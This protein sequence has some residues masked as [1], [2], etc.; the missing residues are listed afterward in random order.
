MLPIEIQTHLEDI[1]GHIEALGA[2]LVDIAVRFG[3]GKNTLIIIADKPQG[4]ITLEECVAVN[5]RLS[6][7]FEEFS[8]Q[9]ETRFL[10]SHYFL[11]VNSPGLD[12]PLKTSKDFNRVSGKEI[13]VV[14]VLE[15]GKTTTA[16]GTLVSVANETLEILTKS[17]IVQTPIA[18]IVKA[19]R[20]ISFKK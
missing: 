13:R 11:E 16:V 3:S 6:D 10:K 2:E 7:Y 1:K 14:Y 15:P 12:R 9:G 18:S 8:N 4:G 20:E 19:L 17:G 5:H